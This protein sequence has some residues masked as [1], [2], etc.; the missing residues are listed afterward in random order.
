MVYNQRGEVVKEIRYLENEGKPKLLQS[1]SEFFVIVTT[2][3]L[4]KIFE[5]DKKPEVKQKSLSR[6]FVDSNNKSYGNI[7]D[8]SINN[9]CSKISILST[10]SFGIDQK[11]I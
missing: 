6:Y 2:T 1:T 7:R 3:N 9:D 5:I 4:I 11:K 8:I 10:D